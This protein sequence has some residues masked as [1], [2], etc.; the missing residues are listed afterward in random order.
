[1][2]LELTD[3]VKIAFLANYTKPQS[4]IAMGFDHYRLKS[5]GQVDIWES[6]PNIYGG[7]KAEG[8]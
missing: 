2:A 3:T 7:L 5:S 4:T 8:R 1:P 6:N